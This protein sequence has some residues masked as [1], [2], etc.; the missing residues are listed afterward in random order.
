MILLS[1]REVDVEALKNIENNPDFNVF[2]ALQKKFSDRIVLGK[3]FKSIQKFESQFSVLTRK[4]DY[5]IPLF[6]EI[7]EN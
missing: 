1:P 6:I 5:I 4:K 2:D 7:I 3:E